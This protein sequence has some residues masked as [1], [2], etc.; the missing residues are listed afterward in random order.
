MHMMAEKPVTHDKHQ[1][2]IYS[3][4]YPELL[5]RSDFYLRELIVLEMPPG[6]RQLHR[7]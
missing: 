7:V 4:S 2:S 1:A 5:S 3:G 6:N